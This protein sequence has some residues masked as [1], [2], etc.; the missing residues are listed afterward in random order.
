MEV[1]EVILIL[2]I[3]LI[4]IKED[5]NMETNPYITMTGT[6]TRFDAD[7]HTFAMML[8]QYI[9]LTHSLL[10]FPIYA[11]FTNWDSKKRWGPD[12]STITFGNLLERLY[13][14]RTLTRDLNLLKLRSPALLILG[15][16]VIWQ[17]LS[18]CFLNADFELES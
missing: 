4:P 8:N 2:F 12:G 16:M 15:L 7:D 17:L 11:H 10:P 1:K 3:K 9:V 5:V 18:V 14:N 13:V 6:V